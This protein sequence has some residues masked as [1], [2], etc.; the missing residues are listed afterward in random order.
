MTTT[1]RWRANV[2]AI[3]FDPRMS[4]LVLWMFGHAN[5]ELGTSAIAR[6]KTVE[7]Q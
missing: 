7:H 5:H 6:E 1:P 2:G 4:D 3:Q